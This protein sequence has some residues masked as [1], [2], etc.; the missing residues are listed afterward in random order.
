MEG[1]LK[2]KRI[3]KGK[4]TRLIT[5][6]DN[7][8]NQENSISV[9]EVHENIVN[10]LDNEI[11]K[12]N[13]DILCSC[14][15][16][17]FDKY[18]QEMHELFDKLFSLKITL[19]DELKKLRKNGNSSNAC[20]NKVNT[21]ASKTLSSLP[22]FKVHRGLASGV[23]EKPNV[24][25]TIYKKVSNNSAYSSQIVANI[26]TYCKS[27]SH[28]RLF[29]CDS[30]L[31]LP[32]KEK[33]D[34]VKKLKLC[35]N[36]L[37]F[38]SHTIDECRE[39]LCKICTKPHNI[40]LCS[41][42]SK[43]DSQTENE[44][45]SISSNNAIVPATQAVLLPTTMVY[46]KDISQNCRLLIDS[47]SQGSFIRESCVNL[48]QLNRSKANISV[49]G[50][51]S[52][53]VG[54][55]AGSVKLQTSSQ[56]NKN[57]S[58]TVDAL[59][60]PK[61]TCDLPQCPV[62]ASVLKTFKQLQLADVNCHQPGPIDIRLGADVFG[63]IMLS[64]HLNVSGISA[65][66]STFGWVIL[67]KTKG[68]S[69]TILSNHASCNAVEFEL[70]KFRQLEEISNVK[71]YT[72]EETACENHFT[73]TFSP[74]STGRF[75]V[76]FPF[77][78]SSNELTN[79][80]QEDLHLPNASLNIDDDAVNTLGIL[81]HPASDVFSFKVNSLFLEG[82]LTKR[83]ILS[84]IAKTF[85]PLGWLSPIT[86]HSK[87]L[88]QKLWKYQLQWDEIV[89]PDIAN[90]WK[91]LLKD[92]LFV[93]DFKISRYLFHDPDKEIS[94]DGFSDASEKAYAAVIY[95]HS[96][97][98]TGQIKVQLVIAK[99]K[100]APLKTISLPRLELCGAL[101]LSKLMDFASKA[102]D[103][104]ISPSNF[105]TDSTIVLAWIGSH[106]SR[107]KT[108]VANR[109]TKIQTLSSP[110]QWHHVSGNENPADLATRGVSSSALLTSVWL[111]G[112]EI[113]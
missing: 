44:L 13:Y 6:V 11:N 77:R 90:E 68:I 56:F 21:N 16:N 2:H 36:C 99:T 92:I 18:E 15:D 111:C 32:N 66:E 46:V 103:I 74:H 10:A 86:I 61:I 24:R 4:L 3:V 26:C 85:N 102:F 84:T 39:K 17:E 31:E 80:I 42:D 23:K 101:L 82:T 34:T 72:Q 87:L 104:P 71:P 43:S 5:E 67:G 8:Q 57:A 35:S 33:W 48:L 29:K 27:S 1:L 63:E 53:K 40:I 52:R 78:K 110:T 41:K 88:M 106:A 69:Q 30:F 54:R 98:N 100:V 107:W 97:S 108:F 7:L 79:L 64:G 95:C 58:I 96:V 37:A 65:S 60:P 76:K 81:W 28:H 62:D 9:I 51:S 109:V 45:P 19:K 20:Q 70:D 14:L 93:K 49:D 47:A 50:L 94:P 12:L 59:I 75:A 73:Q 112:T 25:G 89:P 105:H 55:V 83:T 22:E 91:A 38:K 113:L